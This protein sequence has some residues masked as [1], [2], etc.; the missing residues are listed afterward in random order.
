MGMTKPYDI[1]HFKMSFIINIFWRIVAKDIFSH[2]KQVEKWGFSSSG[3]IQR[4]IIFL[5]VYYVVHRRDYIWMT[6]KKIPNIFLTNLEVHNSQTIHFF[7]IWIHH[8][9]IALEHKLFNVVSNSWIEW[10]QFY[11]PNCLMNNWWSFWQKISQPFKPSFFG[12][13]F[14]DYII[15]FI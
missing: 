5:V 9:L 2:L 14:G 13:F 3:T 7:S 15:D 6:L 12:E 1:W 10:T 8:N 11:P 4:G